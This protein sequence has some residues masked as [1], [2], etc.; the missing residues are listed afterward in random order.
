MVYSTSDH[1]KLLHIFVQNKNKETETKL[2]MPALQI[3]FATCWFCL[4]VN[5]LSLVNPPCSEFYSE[6]TQTP[7]MVLST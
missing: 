4:K 7:R 3:M 2:L 5:F 6:H 1:K